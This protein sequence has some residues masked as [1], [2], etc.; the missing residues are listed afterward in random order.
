[1][2]L[3]PWWEQWPGLLE[4][5]LDDLD[6]AGIRYDVDSAFR[7]EHGVVKVVVWPEVDGQE[8]RMEAFFPD[9]YPWFRP[10][11]VSPEDDLA[12]HQGPFDKN[13]CLLPR[14]TDAWRPGYDSLAG[15]LTTQLPKVYEAQRSRTAPEIEEHQPEPF[16]EY[17]NNDG[18]GALVVDSRWDLGSASHG[19]FEFGVLRCRVPFGQADAP[20]TFVGAVLSVRDETG[21]VIAT[22]ASRLEQRF[23]ER[24]SGRWQRRDGPVLE[25]DARRARELLRR[26]H[27]HL[28]ATDY[29]PLGN[30]AAEADVIGVVFPV[31]AEYGGATVDAWT[32]IGSFAPRMLRKERRS[33][34]KRG[35][36]PKGHA[37]WLPGQRGGPED[38][39]QRIPQLGPMRDK[40][41]LL[42]GAGALGAPAA[43]HFV[44]AGANVD[45]I[46]HDTIEAGTAVRYPLGY[47]DA[48]RYKVAALAEQL[49][50]HSPLSDVGVALARIGATRI[51]GLGD[52]QHE[53][54]SPLLEKADI[55]VDATGSHAVGLFLSDCAAALDVPFLNFTTSWGCWGGRVMALT[56]RTGACFNCVYLHIRNQ[57][58]ADVAPEDRLVPPEMPGGQVRPVGCADAT[59]TG[60]SFDASAVVSVGVR[61]TVS[62]L[63]GG[64]EASY[65]G[66][67][68]NVATIWN[69]LP[70]GTPLA[71]RTYE[72]SV[73]RHED[74]DECTRRSG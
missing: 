24:F 21:K 4:A 33:L 13:L 2:T 1:M 61:A 7:E 54:L 17:Y 14:E 30:G 19:T 27:R 39:A 74:C 20:G 16:T 73:E 52:S 60:T 51:R 67:E 68:W 46:E 66:M 6:T 43:E 69:R 3:Q 49:V 22:A 36:H 58:G 59:Y 32:F 55:I 50:L 34:P 53:L 31:E 8:R 37:H 63:C 62:L 38:L 44:Q 41:V 72:F 12:K 9:L 47:G 40:N 29:Q 25:G 56:P 70:D 23:G 26:E 35:T 18:F 15:I 5:E 48:G 28:A 57:E 45:I 11:V 10:E 42:V 65:P 71:G 64:R